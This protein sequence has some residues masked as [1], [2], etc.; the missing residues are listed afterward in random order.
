M[1]FARREDAQLFLVPLGNPMKDGM[2]EHSDLV[3]ECEVD[4]HKV[5]VRPV[6]LLP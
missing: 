4:V 5:P 3:I 1:K 6:Q 2:R